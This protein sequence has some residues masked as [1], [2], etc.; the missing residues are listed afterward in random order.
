MKLSTS[1]QNKQEMLVNNLMLVM[2]LKSL[3]IEYFFWSFYRMF[4]FLQDNLR[5]DEKE[6]NFKQLFLLWAADNPTI[7]EGLS[8]RN[9]T[10]ISKD[11][12]NELLKL[13]ALN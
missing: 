9:D 5:G 10:Y 6:D 11:I 2:Q 12:Q 7:H 13:V 8:W 4:S 3:E 1:S